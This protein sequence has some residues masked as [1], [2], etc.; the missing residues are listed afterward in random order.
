MFKIALITGIAALLFAGI[1][2]ADDS[3]NYQGT[4]YSPGAATCQSGMQYRCDDGEWKGL[5][6]NCGE[7]HATADTCSFDGRSFSIGSTSCQSGVQYRCEAGSWTN[8]GV[9]CT[10]AGD[11]PLAPLPPARTCMYN[12]ATVASSSTICKSGTTFLCDNGDWRNLGTAC[13]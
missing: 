3:C 7:K 5:G 8:L 10:V 11:Q 4:V 9:T 6:V 13:Q 2:G 1:A 12:G